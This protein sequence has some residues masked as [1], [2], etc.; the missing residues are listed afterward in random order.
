MA[1]RSVSRLPAVRLRIPLSFAVLAV[2]LVGVPA[3]LASPSVAIV[4]ALLFAA[5]VWGSVV[6]WGVLLA[7]QAVVAAYVGL[8]F[9]AVQSIGLGALAMIGI[10][11]LRLLTLVRDHV[12]TRSASRHV[13]PLRRSY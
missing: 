11:S 6:A 1:R 10:V 2:T 9:L 13:R 7:G 4:C 3:V 12:V 5:M 8:A